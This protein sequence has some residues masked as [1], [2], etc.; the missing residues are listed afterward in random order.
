MSAVEKIKAAAA[1]LAALKRDLAAGI[2][3][4]ENERYQT[5][6][7]TNAWQLAEEIG[8]YGRERLKKD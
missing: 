4:L 8:R 5:Y 7:G 1:Q 2:H 3:D 6:E